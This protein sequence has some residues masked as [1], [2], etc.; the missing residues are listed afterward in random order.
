MFSFTIKLV[1]VV[2]LVCAMQGFV[3]GE[4]E[5]TMGW[6]DTSGA[7]SSGLS[8]KISKYGI[9]LIHRDT[10]VEYPKVSIDRIDL[11]T[12]IP[13]CVEDSDN[14]SKKTLAA[15]RTSIMGLVRN[16]TLSSVSR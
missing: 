2:G 13:Y 16:G 11:S 15:N 9:P 3:V 12:R 8:M 14:N 10:T 5:N 7:R 4:I 6:G 1:A